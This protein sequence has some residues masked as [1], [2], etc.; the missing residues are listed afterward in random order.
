ME[1]LP[2]SPPSLSRST[3]KI[4]PQEPRAAR[5]GTFPAVASVS[6]VGSK[7][8]VLKSDP[9]RN[10]KFSG[11]LKGGCAFVFCLLV[12]IEFGKSIHCCVVNRDPLHGPR[13]P[14]RMKFQLIRGENVPRW[15]TCVDGNKRDRLSID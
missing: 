4:D 2:V 11:R 13:L 7:K 1:I 8:K 15:M 10:C 6:P 14:K 5:A 9:G 3:R 12:G